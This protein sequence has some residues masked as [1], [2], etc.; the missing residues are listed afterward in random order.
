MVA[1]V[2]E[3]VLEQEDRVVV[4]EV[5]VSASLDP[6]LKLAGRPMT[7]EEAGPITWGQIRGNLGGGIRRMGGSSPWGQEVTFFD[8]PGKRGFF[9]SSRCLRVLRAL[10][11]HSLKRGPLSLF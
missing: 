2:P 6:A 1:L 10:L 7:D 8:L 5:H 9:C 3:H 11:W 4:V